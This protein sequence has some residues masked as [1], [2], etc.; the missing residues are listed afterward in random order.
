MGRRWVSSQGHLHKLSCLNLQCKCGAP[1]QH[2]VHSASQLPL[3]A[4]INN[5]QRS[6]K[7][8][9][10]YTLCDQLYLGA[11]LAERPEYM[12]QYVNVDVLDV[13]PCV[14][15]CSQTLR[16]LSLSAACVFP[17]E[18]WSYLRTFALPDET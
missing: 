14:V 13:F 8:G 15:S 5:D 7:R 4:E 10:N 12:S 17:S 2:R 16:Q 11:R 9:D 1:T 3:N 6:G 18:A